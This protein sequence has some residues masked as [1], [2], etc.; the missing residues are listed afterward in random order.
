MVVCVFTAFKTNEEYDA[1]SVLTLPK[2][3]L[4]FENFAIAFTQAD[5]ARGGY[6]GYKGFDLAVEAGFTNT[7]VNQVKNAFLMASRH[8]WITVPL[9]LVNAVLPVCLIVQVQLLGALV[10]L[11]LAAGFGLTGYLKAMLLERVFARYEK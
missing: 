8:I 2:N 11:Y 6:Y 4:N 9:V 10:S 7:A 3:F 5:M 1:T